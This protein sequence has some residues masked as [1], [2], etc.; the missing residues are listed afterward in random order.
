MWMRAGTAVTAL[1]SIIAQAASRRTPPCPLSPIMPGK[2]MQR[3]AIHRPL[4][5][6]LSS[7]CQMFALGSGEVEAVEVHDLVPRRHKVVHELL[8]GVS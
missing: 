8:T 6:C 5:S 3:T 7:S 4:H 1:P 2:A